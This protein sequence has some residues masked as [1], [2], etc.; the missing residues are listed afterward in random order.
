MLFFLPMWDSESER[1]GT[2]KCTPVGYG[3]RGIAEMLG[4]TGL[5]ALFVMPAYLIKT[6]ITGEFSAQMLWLLATPFALD[7]LS[8]LFYLGSRLLSLRKDFRYDYQSQEA[9]W[10]EAGQQRTCR[11]PG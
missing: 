11:H 6:L 9:S 3:L 8:E 5:L 7:Y 4:L 10:I 2:W 1:I